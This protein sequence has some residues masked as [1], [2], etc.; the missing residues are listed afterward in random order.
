[1]LPLH[2]LTSVHSVCR[3]C[4]VFRTQNLKPSFVSGIFW[5]FKP[6]SFRNSTM[7]SGF[8]KLFGGTCWPTPTI[9][10]T[11]GINI[12][13]RTWCENSIW[14]SLDL[15]A[16]SMLPWNYPLWCSKEVFMTEIS[17]RLTNKQLVT[18]LDM[19]LVSCLFKL[20]NIWKQHLRSL[21]FYSNQLASKLV[22]IESQDQL[23]FAETIFE[24]SVDVFECPLTTLPKFQ[25]LF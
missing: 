21:S 8:K 16:C 23:N 22:Y 17:Q 20:A 10:M 1:M 4:I 2:K 5:A 6:S 24:K 13:H 7:L 25:F 11:A 12:S 15:F 3:S 18:P 19:D 14:V 9:A